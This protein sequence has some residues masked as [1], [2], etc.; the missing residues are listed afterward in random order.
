MNTK[1]RSVI[2][3]GTDYDLAE[4]LIA[5]GG[6]YAAG[7]KMNGACVFRQA[8]A[9]VYGEVG[10]EEIGNVL[11]E[12]RLRHPDPD[13]RLKSWAQTPHRMAHKDLRHLGQMPQSYCGNCARPMPGDQIAGH[14]N[15]GLPLCGSCAQPAAL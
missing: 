1:I 10:V 12:W 13:T 15:E 3:D 7:G 11:A 9:K 8:L 4:I 14:D 2:D 5:T 6:A